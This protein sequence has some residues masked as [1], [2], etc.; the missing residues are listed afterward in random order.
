MKTNTV[1]KGELIFINPTTKKGRESYVRW[2]ERGDGWCFDHGAAWINL[3]FH[4]DVN[5]AISDMKDYVH[6]FGI[7]PHIKNGV[8]VVIDP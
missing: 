6:L 3:K 5:D 4:T 2:D 7:T 8:F 1:K